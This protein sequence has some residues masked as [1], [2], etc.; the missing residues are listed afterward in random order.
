M[1]RQNHAR[2][3]LPFAILGAGVGALLCGCST[4]DSFRSNP[5]PEL[6]TMSQSPDVVKNQMSY[7]NDTNLR[8]LNEDLGRMWFYDRPMRMMPR[9]APY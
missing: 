5:T 4:A 8:Q 6:M 1:S 3:S 7:V 2:R 9:G